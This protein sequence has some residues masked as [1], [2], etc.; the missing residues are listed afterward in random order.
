MFDKITD[1]GNDVMFAPA[2]FWF[3]LSF[4]HFDVISM[5]D[6]IADQGKLLSILLSTPK[7]KCLL[8]TLEEETRAAKCISSH[9]QSQ[10]G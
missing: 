7:L 5:V 4:E 2:A 6:K 10:E 1:H 8:T 3:H 9:K